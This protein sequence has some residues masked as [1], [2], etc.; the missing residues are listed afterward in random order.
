M[1]D[2]NRT[3]RC[4]I[5]EKKIKYKLSINSA[6]IHEKRICLECFFYSKKAVKLSVLIFGLLGLFI[7]FIDF[8]HP[9]FVITLI[10]NGILILFGL[11][12]YFVFIVLK[13]L[14]KRISFT[15]KK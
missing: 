1:K 8:F 14:R 4:T 9:E 15:Y 2:I 7:F 13:I 12:Y 5:C 3:C 11:F 6:N 10:M